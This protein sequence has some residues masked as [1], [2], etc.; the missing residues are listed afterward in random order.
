[1]T[2][3]ELDPKEYANT[4]IRAGISRR[5]FVNKVKLERWPRELSDRV[6]NEYTNA[7]RRAARLSSDP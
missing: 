7:Q 4:L 1:M 3:R 2:K 5:Q 6:L